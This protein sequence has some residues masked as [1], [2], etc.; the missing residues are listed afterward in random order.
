MSTFI[1]GSTKFCFLTGLKICI[2]LWSILSKGITVLRA[3][4][5][6]MTKTV[7]SFRRWTLQGM[8]LFNSLRA[9]NAFSIL[10]GKTLNAWDYGMQV[11]GNGHA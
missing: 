6:T 9:Y 5:V 8:S 4:G 7:L 3:V 11:R 1:F 2:F 10:A